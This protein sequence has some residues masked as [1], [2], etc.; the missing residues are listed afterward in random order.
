VPEWV[1]KEMLRQVIVPL[2]FELLGNLLAIAQQSKVSVEDLL[3]DSLREYI[4]KHTPPANLEELPRAAEDPT[5]YTT[6]EK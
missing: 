2:P 1:A 5:K 4:K 6:P 3:V